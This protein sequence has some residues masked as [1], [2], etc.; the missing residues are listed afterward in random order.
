MCETGFQR[1]FNF[2]K[3]GRGKYEILELYETPLPIEDSRSRGNNSGNISIK[4]E[5]F[6]VYDPKEAHNP[7]VYK[8]ENDFYIYIGSTMRGLTER[9]SE[10]FHNYNHKQ[11]ATQQ[12]LLNGGIF[13]CLESF[14][15]DVEERVVRK[16]EADFIK[17]YKN[18]NKILVNERM[19][20]SIDKDIEDYVT[21]KIDKI[22]MEDFLKKL[23]EINYTL[24]D[25]F[26]YKI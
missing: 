10:H 22:Y 3:V 16:R 6:A 18:T 24:I 8:I 7:G 1:F 23:S 26:I 5:C 14:E 19:L 4:E 13:T 12:I 11:N 9:F 25:G 15:K 2:E 17:K 20:Y 21:I